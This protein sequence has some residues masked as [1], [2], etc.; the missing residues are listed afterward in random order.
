MPYIYH[1]KSFQ[2]T[3][4]TFS[5]LIDL[6]IN[7]IKTRYNRELVIRISESLHNIITY[8]NYSNTTT[9]CLV[10]TINTSSFSVL[11]LHLL[12]FIKCICLK[13]EKYSLQL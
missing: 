3:Q 8:N 12:L 2:I 6:Y 5:Q 7:R 9:Q 11:P 4:R 10:N 13:T 1:A